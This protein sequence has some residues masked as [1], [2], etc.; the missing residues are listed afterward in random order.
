MCLCSGQWDKQK[1]HVWYPG[2]MLKECLFIW[3]L[4]TVC[5]SP[6]LPS[7]FSYSWDGWRSS[8]WA[9]PLSSLENN[10]L[11]LRKTKQ[12]DRILLPNYYYD[13]TTIAKIGFPMAWLLLNE[14]LICLSCCYF[15]RVYEGTQSRW[16]QQILLVF[17]IMSVIQNLLIQQIYLTDM[18]WIQSNFGIYFFEYV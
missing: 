2:R 8:H 1:C 5:P 16:I 10:G 14:R 6:I 12:K 15:R 3:E 7:C 4:H 18:H 13:A 9:G 11:I 17:Q